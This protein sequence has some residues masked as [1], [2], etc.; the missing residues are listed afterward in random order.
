M[1]C[2]YFYF[3]DQSKFSVFTEKMAKS[4][5]LNDENLIYCT[6]RIWE[7][8]KIRGFTYNLVVKNVHLDEKNWKSILYTR[9]QQQQHL[10]CN[11]VSQL[12]FKMSHCP[13]AGMK[14]FNWWSLF[15][16]LLNLMGTCSQDTGHSIRACQSPG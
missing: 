6:I 13:L 15:L 7:I 5:N 10:N 4:F 3:W 1:S 9:L 2:P 16:V 11:Q 14:I 8:C 12:Q